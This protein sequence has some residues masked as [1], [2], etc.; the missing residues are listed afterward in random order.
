[1]LDAYMSAFK[2]ERQSKADELWAMVSCIHST[3][4]ISNL[5]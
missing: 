4:H 1:M 5:L 2:E 3:L